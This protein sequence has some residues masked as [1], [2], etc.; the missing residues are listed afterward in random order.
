M[1]IPN[2]LTVLR[3][4][5]IPFF[6][7]AMLQKNMPLAATLFILLS[8]TDFL[9]GFLA[10]K[11]N[12][13]TTFG[14]IAD[15]IADKFLTGAAF[16]LLVPYGLPLWIVVVIFAR[17]IAITLL[18]LIITKKN[19][20][21]AAS[22]LGKLKTITQIIAIILTILSFPFWLEIMYIATALTVISALDYIIKLTKT[23]SQKKHQS[24]Q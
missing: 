17:E 1:N 18:R 5:G 20:I 14:K 24:S 13:I 21:V 3:I 12:Q 11:L 22:L 2:A 7:Y 15:P 19:T 23:L 6:I 8:I 16:I 4:L 10:R 9:D